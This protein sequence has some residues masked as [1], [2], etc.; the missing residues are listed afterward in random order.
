MNA[1]LSSALAFGKPASARA[2]AS[3]G[4]STNVIRLRR[5]S[6][7]ASNAACEIVIGPRLS[8]SNAGDFSIPRTV[9]CSCLPAIDVTA[10][11]EPTPRPCLD[12]K[13]SLTSAP[14]RPSRASPAI[15]SNRNA[16][17]GGIDR[18]D[19][20]LGAEGQRAVLAHRA[21]VAEPGRR[22]CSI[23]GSIGDQPS[24]AVTIVCA[25][26]WSASWPRPWSSRPWATMVTAVTS[27]TPII[28]A[29]A[30]TAVR[31]GLRIALSRASRPAAPPSRAA[32]RPTTLAT[33]RTARAKRRTLTGLA[34]SRSAA[35]GRDPRRAAGGDR[36]GEHRR[37]RADEQR[38]DDRA[39]RELEALGRQ[40]HAER[41]EELVQAGGEPD[42]DADAR[43]RGQQADE[44]RLQQH[45][46]AHLAAGRADHP[47]Q[48]ELLRALR[49]GDRERVED[50]ERADQH[51]DAGEGEQDVRM[52][53]TN[54]SSESNVK[55]SSA[56][57]L[58]TSA[59]G[60]AAAIDART[61]L[62]LCARTRMRS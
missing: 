8:T 23:L 16:R 56:A 51:R 52:M 22:R 35:T 33:P 57:A 49:D 5:W 6:N 17:V 55:R 31:P 58:R 18:V 53:L 13:P 48:P 32:G 46:E 61:S 26:T 27:A 54:S 1:S 29:D 20:L 21:D 11:V 42:A 36:G 50:R 14:S 30:V 40:L 34:L 24:V 37:Q 10:K 25:C 38:D 15:T 43:R 47:Q 62:R 4:A 60:T 2:T 3:G 7:V 45:A 9:S 19:A 44:Q 41:G 12:A 39:R 59:V 28:S